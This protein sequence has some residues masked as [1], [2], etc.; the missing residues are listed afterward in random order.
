[1]AKPEQEKAITY[2]IRVAG[3]LGEVW[4]E[5]VQGM[6]VSVRRSEPKGCFT[7]LIG[8]LPDEA[9]LMGVLDALYMH[10]ARL[11]SVERV[12]T[13]GPT[14]PGAGVFN[15]NVEEDLR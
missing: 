2:C 6:A 7:E 11:L 8:E 15:R 13:D 9:A 4:S 10:G 14:A 3:V 12:E 5:L 1:M